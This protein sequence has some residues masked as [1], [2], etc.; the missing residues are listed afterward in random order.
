M[1]T[2]ILMCYQQVDISIARSLI[3]LLLGVPC[4]NNRIAL[5]ENALANIGKRGNFT[6]VRSRYLISIRNNYLHSL[7]GGL[8]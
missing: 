6:C 5:E 1:P 8:I 7:C 2:I 3:Q 4:T